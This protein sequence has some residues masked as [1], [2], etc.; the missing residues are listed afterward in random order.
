MPRL[1]PIFLGGGAAEGI[2]RNLIIFAIVAFVKKKIE[3][4]FTSLI[5]KIRVSFPFYILIF[6]KQGH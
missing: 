3:T 1:S 2:L 4:V 5:K 6:N